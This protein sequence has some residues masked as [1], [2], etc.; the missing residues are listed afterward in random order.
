MWHFVLKSRPLSRILVE[1]LELWA[2]WCFAE[3]NFKDQRPSTRFAI[4]LWKKHLDGR[5]DEQPGPA[6]LL[7]IYSRPRVIPLATLVKYLPTVSLGYIDTVIIHVPQTDILSRH[8][9][10]FLNRLPHLSRYSIA[11]DDPYHPFEHIAN[12][13][14]PFP[15]TNMGAY[16]VHQ[17]TEIELD[18][19]YFAGDVSYAQN[20]TRLTCLSP[21]R[22]RPIPP[23][24]KAS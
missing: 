21:T 22:S 1:R 14:T 20:F 5:A 6:H 12:R 4:N 3:G 9:F 24:K 10:Q 17:A 19:L 8:L 7:L 13:P 15:L 16:P 2:D 11:T 23:A 18:A